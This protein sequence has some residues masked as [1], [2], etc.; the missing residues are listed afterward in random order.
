LLEAR[1]AC[2]GYARQLGLPSLVVVPQTNPPTPASL[3]NLLAEVFEA[4]VAA[5][6]LQGGEAMAEALLRRRLP[7]ERLTAALAAAE[8]SAASAEGTVAVAAAEG[9]AAARQ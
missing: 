8:R 1:A 3:P 9:S 6:A 5:V 2:L 7:D 4:V